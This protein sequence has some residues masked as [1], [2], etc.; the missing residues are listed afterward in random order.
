MWT[1]VAFFNQAPLRLPFLPF[2]EPRVYVGRDAGALVV[3]PLVSI[4]HLP[5]LCW[6]FASVRVYPASL[7]GKVKR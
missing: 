3:F 5:V 7:V 1:F 2:G 4:A 6:Q